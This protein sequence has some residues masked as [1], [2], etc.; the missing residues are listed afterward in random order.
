M[1]HPPSGCGL[2]QTRWGSHSAATRDWPGG[3][4]RGGQASTG[5][6]RSPVVAPAFS[7]TWL[8]GPNL[9]VPFCTVG[10]NWKCHQM[11]TTPS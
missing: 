6:Q 1:S 10:A 4:G 2:G 8:Q 9:T 11:L 7:P 5:T 3:P